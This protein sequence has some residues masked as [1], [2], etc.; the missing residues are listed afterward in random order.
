MYAHA[1]MYVCTQVMYKYINVHKTDLNIIHD[2]GSISF[3][4]VPISQLNIERYS[5]DVGNSTEHKLEIFKGSG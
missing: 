4:D 3:T 5:P 1:Y 2:Q